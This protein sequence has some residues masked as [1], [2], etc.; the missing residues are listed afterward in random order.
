MKNVYIDV[1]KD[2]MGTFLLGDLDITEHV[3]S[4]AIL[5]QPGMSTMIEIEL[6]GDLLVDAKEAEVN[7]TQPV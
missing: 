7:V 5:I 1:A 6:T 3:R 4:V 2:S